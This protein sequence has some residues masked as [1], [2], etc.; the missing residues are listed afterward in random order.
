MA[1]IKFSFLVLFYCISFPAS[2]QK[3]FTE[4]TITYHVK[5]E[6]NDQGLKPGTYIITTKGGMVRKEMKLPGLDYTIIINCR[7]NKVYSLQNRNGKKYAI[8]LTMEDLVKDQEKFK[9]FILSSTNTDDN[10]I[11]GC[12]ATWSDVTYKDGVSTLVA[13]SKD[14]K[15]AQ[16]VTFER[17]PDAAFIPLDF[18]YTN[19]A[20]VSVRFEAEK[21]DPGPVENAVFRIPADYKIISNSEY[22]EMN[23]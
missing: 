21:I 9:G 17:F 13:Y 5:M 11:A 3:P 18:L 4:G 19:E 7:T 23:K 6:P 12:Q 16:S 14:W 20:G 2:A 10:K 22:R 1:H 8:E 15:P